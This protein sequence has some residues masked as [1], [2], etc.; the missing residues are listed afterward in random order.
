[1]N[2]TNEKDKIKNF[3]EYSAEEQEMIR[4]SLKKFLVRNQISEQNKELRD[5][6]SK[7]SSNYDAV[8]YNFNNFNSCFM[9]VDLY[10]LMNSY[11]DLDEYTYF[12]RP[13][14]ERKMFEF[15]YDIA[16][17]IFSKKAGERIPNR[18]TLPI[19][20]AYADMQSKVLA[21][22]VGNKYDVDEII[23]WSAREVRKEYQEK[24]GKPLNDSEI[25]PLEEAHKFN[26][27]SNCKKWVSYLKA[28]KSELSTKTV[29]EMKEI[30][31][32]NLFLTELER[33]RLA[34]NVKNASEKAKQ[35]VK[36][37][38]NSFKEKS[39]IYGEDGGFEFNEYANPADYDEIFSAEYIDDMCSYYEKNIIQN[40]VESLIQE[41]NKKINKTKN[42]SQP[43]DE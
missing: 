8:A 29:A 27:K 41:F 24:Y 2:I 3:S 18:V 12:S 31:E 10:S 9:G 14:N 25:Q 19:M 35:I 38:Q 26:T 1:M 15:N 6:F 42:G 13:E 20:V 11:D 40:E 34:R 5:H 32:K 17:A 4:F 39:L 37:Q 33:E 7:K 36:D 28:L 30:L 23:E 16:R 43:G 22:M 21:L